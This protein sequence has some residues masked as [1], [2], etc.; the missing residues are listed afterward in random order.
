MATV[1]FPQLD[2]ENVGVLAIQMVPEAFTITS[3]SLLGK[4]DRRRIGR[5]FGGRWRGIMRFKAQGIDALGQRELPIITDWM[6]EMRDE[7][8][9]PP[10]TEVPIIE[11]V[12]RAGGLF[13]DTPATLAA[14][15]VTTQTRNPDDDPDNP[16]EVVTALSTSV[17]T[18]Q[19]G[20]YLNIAVTRTLPAGGTLAKEML[21]RVKWIDSAQS[22]IIIRPEHTIAS[23]TAIKRAEILRIR[24]D[25]LADPEEIPINNTTG[26]PFVAFQ[27][28]EDTF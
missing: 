26:L 4:V 14:A 12:N 20:Q 28:V 18:L 6:Q 10:V 15:T 22:R 2:G 13:L 19:K 17:P 3:E 11:F 16:G 8:A 24:T 7:G 1:K 21:V 25:F 9:V 27:F 5:P 23:G